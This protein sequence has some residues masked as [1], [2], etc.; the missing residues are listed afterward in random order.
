MLQGKKGLSAV[1]V[2]MLLVLL[3]IVIIGVVWVS[4]QSAVNTT[5]DELNAR[6]RCLGVDIRPT[7][8]DEDCDTANNG[9]KITFKRVAGGKEIEGVVVTIVSKN[10]TQS[11]QSNSS[12]NLNELELKT[13]DFSTSESN[14]TVGSTEVAA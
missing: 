11:S 6:A 1:I 5:A 8:I 14:F 7:Q 10:E 2:S 13:L 12:G 3:G 9:C 4:I